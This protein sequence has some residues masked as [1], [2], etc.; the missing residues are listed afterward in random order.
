MLSSGGRC[1]VWLLSGPVVAASLQLL[2][3]IPVLPAPCPHHP[4]SLMCH[5]KTRLSSIVSSFQPNQAV[6]CGLVGDLTF[7]IGR[8][9]FLESS[10]NVSL[11]TE[12]Q[13][14]SLLLYKMSELSDARPQTSLLAWA[15]TWRYWRCAST[16]SIFIARAA[17]HHH[18]WML[19]SGSDSNFV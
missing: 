1:G 9:N 10:S 16:D 19:R 12:E 8:N 6:G 3:I 5:I 7:K 14:M 18:F 11:E 17:S 4:H 15:W 2:C 13:R